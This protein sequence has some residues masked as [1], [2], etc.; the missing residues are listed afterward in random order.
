MRNVAISLGLEVEPGQ[1]VFL[2][3][4]NIKV[5][6]Y[7]MELLEKLLKYFG[8]PHGVRASDVGVTS[9]N[10]IP[11][12]PDECIVPVFCAIPMGWTLASGLSSGIGR[13]GPTGR[14]RH[15]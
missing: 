7:A 12:R 1:Q 11:N 2:G 15:S 3:N 14:R 10:G 8:L 13:T 9:I 4:A 5:A 6:F